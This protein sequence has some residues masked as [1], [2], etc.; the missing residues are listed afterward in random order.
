MLMKA[1]PDN[2]TLADDVEAGLLATQAPFEP[3]VNEAE[4]FWH[5]V[6]DVQLAQLA[7]HAVQFYHDEA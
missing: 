6:A 3:N 5:V 4:Q 7:G 2:N 1:K